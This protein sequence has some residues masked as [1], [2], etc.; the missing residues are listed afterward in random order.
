M[1]IYA[2]IYTHTPGKLQPPRSPSHQKLPAQPV[3]QKWGD[4]KPA[5]LLSRAGSAKKMVVE[6]TENGAPAAENG[7]PAADV[8]KKDAVAATDG[9]KKDAKD[10]QVC[11]W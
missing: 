9:A 5:G 8:V 11:L 4:I 7:V 10:V 6:K 1:H 2:Y 3:F